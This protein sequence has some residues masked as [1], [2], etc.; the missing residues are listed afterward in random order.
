MKYPVTV[1]YF[2]IV[3]IFSFLL[4]GLDKL[5]AKASARRVREAYFFILAALGGSVGVY[6]GMKVFHHKTLH[7]SFSAGIPS[8]I[9]L[10]L[11][12]AAAL[13]HFGIF[14]NLF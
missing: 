11:A 12:A 5:L 2:V 6:L 14:Q 4:M 7:R 8:I 1:Y 9:L 3:N 10:Q 13:W